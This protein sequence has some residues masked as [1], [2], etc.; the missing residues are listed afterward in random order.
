M[1]HLE[2]ERCFRVKRYRATTLHKKQYF[3]LPKESK[4]S[5]NL[6]SGEANLR[7]GS[8]NQIRPIAGIRYFKLEDTYDVFESSSGKRT[9][10]SSLTNNSLF[11][12]QLGLES[13]LRHSR[14]L[15]LYGFG[16]VAAMH[17]EV[18]GGIAS[19]GQSA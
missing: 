18:E 19:S 12:G 4:Y 16:K 1:A 11:G 10:F 9:V 13:D 5:T 2:L 14:R 8:R 15:N 6:Y 7:F 17:N 3:R